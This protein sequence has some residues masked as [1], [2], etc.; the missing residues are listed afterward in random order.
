MHTEY[1]F[2]GHSVGEVTEIL[3]T[4]PRGKL[5]GNSH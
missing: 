3:K 1:L 2:Y 5:K 4:F